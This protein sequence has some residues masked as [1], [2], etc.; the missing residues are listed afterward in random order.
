MTQIRQK[1][2]SLSSDENFKASRD[3]LLRFLRSYK[4]N[5]RISAAHKQ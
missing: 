3:W 5:D 2:L 1:A 4:L